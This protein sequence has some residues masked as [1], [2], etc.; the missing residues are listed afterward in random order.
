MHKE[1]RELRSSKWKAVA[2]GIALAVCVTLLLGVRDLGKWLT[3][4]DPPSPVD[5]V[6]VLSG[7]APYRAEEAARMYGMR[8][9]PEVWVTRPEAPI[10]VSDTLA[11]QNPAE[12]GYTRR[13]L[14]EEGVS[15][16]SIEILPATVINTEEELDEV[17]TEM[18]RARKKTV[19]IVTSPQHTR[20]T[21]TLWKMLAKDDL[22]AVVRA[23]RGDPFDAGHWWRH[24]HDASSVLHELLGLLNAWMGLPARP[25]SRLLIAFRRS[26]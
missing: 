25:R 13:T 19:M 6:V 3:D 24:S 1:P 8:Y 17:A 26:R 2:S 18:R 20:R 7:G 10:D 5:V 22:I 14:I 21:R 4:E 11:G 12:E 15:T 9:A 16:A 23:A